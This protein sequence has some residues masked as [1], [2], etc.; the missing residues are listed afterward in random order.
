[1]PAGRRGAGPGASGRHGPR[2]RLR[3]GNHPPARGRHRD[4]G[5]QLVWYA[6][7]R[8]GA[9]QAAAA[10]AAAELRS[11]RQPAET[12]A[13]PDALH[14]GAAQRTGAQLRQDALP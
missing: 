5:K 7:E 2:L 14:A 8:E 3:G 9:G 10:A 1:M 12:E 6:G 13:A 11:A 4:C